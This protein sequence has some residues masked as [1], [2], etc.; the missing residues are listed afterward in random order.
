M[1]W[2]FL[3]VLKIS[4]ASI[5]VFWSTMLSPC[6][7]TV[8]ANINLSVQPSLEAQKNVVSGTE[9][10]IHKWVHK[11]QGLW[12]PKLRVGV[13]AWCTMHFAWILETFAAYYRILLLRPH[14]AQAPAVQTLCVCVC[15]RVGMCVTYGV[16]QSKWSFLCCLMWQLHTLTGRNGRNYPIQLLSSWETI[17]KWQVS[18]WFIYPTV[19]APLHGEFVSI[20]T[21]CYFGHRKLCNTLM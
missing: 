19:G 16:I 4:C 20:G 21:W 7:C 9:Y 11:Q 13:H 3:C 2:W 17:L 8:C 5:Q 6:V 10:M 1:F 18:P 14:C 15:A 12:E